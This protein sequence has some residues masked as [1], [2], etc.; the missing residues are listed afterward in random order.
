MGFILEKIQGKLDLLKTKEELISAA[1]VL[2]VVGKTEWGKDSPC[3]LV[4]SSAHLGTV[5]SLSTLEPCSG[6]T[7]F[8]TSY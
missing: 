4:V 1:P 6:L 3:W 5:F 2:G 8:K 7:H